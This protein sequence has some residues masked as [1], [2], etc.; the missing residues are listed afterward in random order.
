MLSLGLNEEEMEESFMFVTEPR[1][2]QVIA[3]QLELVR[4]DTEANPVQAL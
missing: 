4:A 3:G 2:K 1:F